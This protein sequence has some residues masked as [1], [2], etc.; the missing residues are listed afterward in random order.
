M[1]G[2]CRVNTEVFHRNGRTSILGP[3]L[4]AI[5]QTQTGDIFESVL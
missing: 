4:N 1:D 3:R 5:E 2:F